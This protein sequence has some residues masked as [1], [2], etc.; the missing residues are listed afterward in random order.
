MVS[1][2]LIS[3]ILA[4]RD[5]TVKR[6]AAAKTYER[7]VFRRKP[8]KNSATRRQTGLP[9]LLNVNYLLPLQRFSANYPGV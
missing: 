6:E 2:G 7:Y 3:A 4:D 9:L 1:D 5:S 8:Q